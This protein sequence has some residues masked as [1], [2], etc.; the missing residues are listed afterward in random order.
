MDVKWKVLLKYGGREILAML[1]PGPAADLHAIKEL[2][3]SKFDALA[4]KDIV[5]Q[6]YDPDFK[7]LVDLSH[8]FAATSNQV[9]QVVLLDQ[10]LKGSAGKVRISIHGMTFVLS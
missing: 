8:P 9:F 4:G 6:T 7:R 3:K 5:I 1:P 2:A 10:K